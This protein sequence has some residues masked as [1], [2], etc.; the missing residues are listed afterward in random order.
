MK[1][2]LEGL[3]IGLFFGMI[4]SSGLLFIGSYKI[5]LAGFFL[6]IIIAFTLWGLTSIVKYWMRNNN[7]LNLKLKPSTL[8]FLLGLAGPF[9]ALAYSYVNNLKGIIPLFIYM[10][11]ILFSLIGF[12]VGVYIEQKQ[13]RKSR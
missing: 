3:I 1:Y 2:N 12:L 9:L 4:F 8:G 5:R 6:T 7:L 13:K 10:F 11:L